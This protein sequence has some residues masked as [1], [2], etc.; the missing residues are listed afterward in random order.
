MITNN[1]EQTLTDQSQAITVRVDG[2]AQFAIDEALHYDHHAREY[3]SESNP[4]LEQETAAL[5]AGVQAVRAAITFDVDAPTPWQKATDTRGTCVNFAWAMSGVV[6]DLGMTSRL[7]HCN[8]HVMNVVIGKT[9][10]VHVINADDLPHAW[11]FDAANQPDQPLFNPDQIAA[12]ASVTDSEATM[13]PFNTRA[14]ERGALIDQYTSGNR[15]VTPKLWMAANYAGLTVMT[16]WYAKQAL[17]NR[18]ELVEALSNHNIYGT[19]AVL[20]KMARHNFDRESRPEVNDVLERFLRVA[21]YWIRDQTVSDS[22]ISMTLDTYEGLLEPSGA[23]QL[24]FGDSWRYLAQKR[25]SI[26]ALERAEQL[27]ASSDSLNPRQNVINL[28][29]VGKQRKLTEVEESIRRT[30]RLGSAK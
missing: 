6:Q 14:L 23:Q 27:Y 12:I 2:P 13:L 18:S 10:A 11:Y 26:P 5:R 4:S 17:Q 22:Q 30:N 15:R 19:G 3:W 28:V 25:R 8:G 1:N 20:H 9:G 24:R 7:G 21:R 29:L 16:P